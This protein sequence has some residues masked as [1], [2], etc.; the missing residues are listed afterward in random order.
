MRTEIGDARSLAIQA[1]SVLLRSGFVPLENIP[2]LRL[3]SR[4]I[5]K[6]SVVFAAEK[7]RLHKVLSDEGGRFSVVVRDIRGSSA[8]AMIGGLFVGGTSEHALSDHGKHLKV[9]QPQVLDALK[10]GSVTPATSCC[11][12]CW[13]GSWSSKGASGTSNS[14]RSRSCTHASFRRKRCRPSW[15]SMSSVPPC[16]W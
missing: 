13:R 10:G 7:N 14:V 6:F 16:C 1:N 11:A 4:N 3:V 9:R 15:G 12:R 2:G 5:M 8:R